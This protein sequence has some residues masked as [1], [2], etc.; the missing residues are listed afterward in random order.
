MPSVRR[1]VRGRCRVWTRAQAGCRGCCQTTGCTRD[2]RAHCHRCRR[3]GC[4]GVAT[5]G[6]P[7][8][9]H[10]RT[11]DSAKAARTPPPPPPMAEAVREAHCRPR[12]RVLRRVLTAATPRWSRARGA[13]PRGVRSTA[14]PRESRAALPPAAPAAAA[15]LV[16]A[17][18]AAAV[19][20][21]ADGRRAAV[22]AR[23]RAP[24][25]AVPR[26]EPQQPA[27]GRSAAGEGKQARESRMMRG[28]PLTSQ[29][30]GEVNEHN[31]GD[32]RLAA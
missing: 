12:G 13:A 25:G 28:R 17:A 20:A 9:R 3:R 21:A 32:E 23:A 27:V 5:R 7:R 31:C 1:P 2:P 26:P 19:A 10:V 30:G 15:A 22:H 16:A 18:A 14:S 24:A 11:R 6:A 29:E 8:R 4:R